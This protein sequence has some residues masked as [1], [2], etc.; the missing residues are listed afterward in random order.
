MPGPAALHAACAQGP[1]GRAPTSLEAARRLLALGCAGT[2]NPVALGAHIRRRLAS[3][4]AQQRALSGVPGFGAASAG[5][6][7]GARRIRAPARVPRRPTGGL[8]LVRVQ[9]PPQ[10]AGRDHANGGQGGGARH[11]T[12]GHVPL[13]LRGAGDGTAHLVTLP[14]VGTGAPHMDPVGAAG[15]EDAAGVGFRRPCR[16]D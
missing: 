12:V 10:A 6:L 14:A 5:H 8:Q 7:Q 3:P 2:A 9:H 13:L 4:H 16:Y 11:S 1:A 15:G